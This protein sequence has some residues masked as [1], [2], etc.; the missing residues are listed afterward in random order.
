MVGYLHFTGRRGR[1]RL[2]SH[3]VLGM[4][5]WEA[6]L[7]GGEDGFFARR[8]MGKGLD[9]LEDA[10]CRRLLMACSAAPY[11]P[12]VHTRSLWQAMAAPLA[13]AAL[14]ANGMEPRQSVVALRG[15]RMTRSYLRACTALARE[16]RALSLALEREEALGWDLQQEL[17]IPLVEGAA[18]VTLSFLP[19]VCTPG[20]FALGGE[21]PKISG[22]RPVLPGLEPPE[23]CPALPLLAALLDE[24]RLPLADVLIVPDFP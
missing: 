2:Q 17:G 21:D 1:V 11:Y 8:R 7:P 5:V 13:L 3:S 24:G 22:F 4:T 12:V 19:G 10:G 18:A 16:V 20:Y 15:D 6:R 14:R 23:G 9:R